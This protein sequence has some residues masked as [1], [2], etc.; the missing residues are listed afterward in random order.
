M[1]KEFYNTD[2]LT[3][4][5]PLYHI[6][7]YPSNHMGLHHP[8]RD[9]NYDFSGKSRPVSTKAAFTFL[10]TLDLKLTFKGH[11]MTS[12]TLVSF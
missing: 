11:L 8:H 3:K 9:L 5:L 2:S 10:S 6:S 1:L 4:I 12:W 7:I